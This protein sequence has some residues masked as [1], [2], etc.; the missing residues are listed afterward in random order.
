MAWSTVEALAP[1]FFVIALGWGC[2]RWRLIDN[3]D[4]SS[5]NTLVMQIAIPVA[6]FAILAS[7]S[8]TD[9]LG[10]A[11]MAAVVL[12]AMTVVY[13]GVFV[14]GRRH[15][16]RSSDAA[17]QALT[18]A[19]PNAAAVGL[20]LAD[21][22]MGP[23]GALTVAVTLAVGSVTLSPVTILLVQRDSGSAADGGASPRLSARAVAV[24][25]AKPIVIAPLLGLVYSLSG[26]P[27][28][29]VVD[30]TLSEIGMVSA[31]LALF[32]TGLV[33]SAQRIEITAGAVVSTIVSVLVRPAIAY[34]LALAFALPPAATADAV[35]IMA[36][37]AGF[38]GVLLGLS[39]GAKSALAGTTLL[40]STVLAAV[41][42]PLVITWLPR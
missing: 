24:A 5:L 23:T 35:L 27:L 7:S 29:H 30:A 25:L 6:L 11:P 12:L 17:I 37:P 34:A 36:V 21:T 32:L 22:V 42:L 18:V 13:A 40:L 39:L 38:F 8:R 3:V 33:L 15:H 28:P 26:V 16:G 41:T 10:H 31:G 20:P 1:V 2:G 9:L 19:F 4:V 14:M